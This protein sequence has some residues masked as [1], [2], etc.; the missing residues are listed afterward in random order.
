MTNVLASTTRAVLEITATS[1]AGEG[2]IVRLSLIVG[3]VHLDL[4]LPED[5]HP[6]IISSTEN[7]AADD[8]SQPGWNNALPDV[9]ADSQTR[10]MQPQT[11]GDEEHIGYDVIE[12]QTHKRK[13]W[14]PHADDL[15]VE[16][17]GLHAKVACETD[18][19]VAADTP[20]ED[21]VEL[22][23]DLFAGHNRDGLV[24]VDPMVENT[25]V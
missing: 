15:G 18:K 6:I 23:L 8:I 11:Q 1:V 2:V 16:V 7:S 5:E 3:S 13:D 25:S 12:A 17:L 19:P 14:P 21:L 9:H 20:E 10:R 22:R 4:G 24:F